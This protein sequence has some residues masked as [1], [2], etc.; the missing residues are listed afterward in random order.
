[1]FL[2]LLV[3]HEAHMVQG[4]LPSGELQVV[5][6]EVAS[7]LS[8]GASPGSHPAWANYAEGSEPCQNPLCSL[9]GLWGQTARA[10]TRQPW[11]SS[12]TSPCLSFLIRKM[13]HYVLVHE[14][15]SVSMSGM[16]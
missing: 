8:L 11:T 2:K 10:M 15:H 4:R 13:G 16:Q 7:L 6:A 14:K 1:M 9:P 5:P 12:P 3:L